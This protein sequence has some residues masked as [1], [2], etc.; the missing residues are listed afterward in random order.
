MSRA[1][2]SKATCSITGCGKPVVGRRLCRKHY[3]RWHKH[4][5]A[6]GGGTPKGALPAWLEAHRAFSG[7]EC[8]TWPFTTRADGIAQIRVLGKS[9]TAHRAMRI[10]AHGEPPSPLHDAAHSCGKAH[11]GCVNPRH[12]R[13]ATKTENQ[14]D[15]LSHGTALLGEKNPASKLS[16]AAITEILALKGTATQKAVAVRFGICRQHVG[17]IWSGTRRASNAG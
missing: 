1:E 4:G 12:L 7:D 8:L 9:M 6:N 5:D 10:L 3:N 2:F 14:A 13:W 16:D 15:R 11:R 17:A